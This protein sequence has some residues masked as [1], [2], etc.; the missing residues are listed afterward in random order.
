MVKEYE[1]KYEISYTE[2]NQ[3]LELSLTRAVLK[4][5]ERNN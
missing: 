3:N 1:S 5:K 2:A 4:Y